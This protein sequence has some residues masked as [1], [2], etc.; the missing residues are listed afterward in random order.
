MAELPSRSVRSRS[1]THHSLHR[2]GNI[3]SDRTGAKCLLVNSGYFLGFD[4]IL[5]SFLRITGSAMAVETIGQARAEASV[6]T[7]IPST[8]QVP[9]VPLGIG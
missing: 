6:F 5:Y 4:Q 2:M 3:V 8:R 9:Y 7:T 1:R